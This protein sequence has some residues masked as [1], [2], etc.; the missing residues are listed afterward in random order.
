[1]DSPQMKLSVAATVHHL[2]LVHASHN[3]VSRR[4]IPLSGRYLHH[5]TEYNNSLSPRLPPPRLCALLV[6]S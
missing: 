2:T 5:E 3:G 6:Q 4:A 1:M